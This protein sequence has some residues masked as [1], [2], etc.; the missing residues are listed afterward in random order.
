MIFFI[1]NQLETCVKCTL[2]NPLCQLW[3][4]YIAPGR[5]TQRFHMHLLMFLL[6]QQ[7]QPL[8]RPPNAHP[9]RRRRF[10]PSSA[11]P[12]LWMG[13]GRPLKRLKLLKQ[14]KHKQMHMKSLSLSARSYI[15]RPQLAK[16]IQ[17]SRTCAPC[18]GKHLT[19][20]R[21]LKKQNLNYV[22]CL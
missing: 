13:V 16:R 19:K 20:T 14:Q 3:P 2:L 7:L 5:D 18:R 15:F 8:Q 1:S 21:P 4:K 11:A 10:P 22:L 12:P 6:R 17:E 9:Q